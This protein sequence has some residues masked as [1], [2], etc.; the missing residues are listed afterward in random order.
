VSATPWRIVILS[1]VPPAAIGIDALARAAGHDPVALIAPRLA[2]DATEERR[3]LFHALVEAAP[4]HLDLCLVPSKDRIAPLLH[5]YEPDLAICTGYP[6]LIPAEALAIPRLGIVNGHPSLLPRH[7]GP[8]PIAWAFREGDAQ[9]GFTFHLMDEQFDT[10]PIL[11]Q[12]SRPMPAEGGFQHLVPLL[13]ELAQELL[14]RALA[15][16][17]AG[18][19]GDVQPAEGATY[20]GPFS[21]E[22]AW[23]DLSRPAI[24]VHNLVRGWAAAWGFMGE[25]GPLVELDGERRRILRTTLE[26]PGD[27]GLRLE[28]GDGPLWV[29]EHEPA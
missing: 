4:R 19:R 26:D 3:E 15:R 14:P 20:A 24:E 16:L 2:E 29:L 9:L 7:R 21:A 11:A 28:C 8:F 5:R 10:G 6:W 25:R 13:G 18:D 17:A 1:T 27:G 22:D 23:L 12:G